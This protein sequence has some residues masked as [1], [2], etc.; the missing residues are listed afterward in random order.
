[1]P[2][3]V[4]RKTLLRLEWPQVLE[5]L[6]RHARTARGR[7]RLGQAPEAPFAADPAAA[8]LQLA[9][10]SEARGILDAGELPP[11]EANE[12]VDALLARLQR[13]GVLSGPE[14]LGLAASARVCDETRRV[15]VRRAEAAP[16]LAEL[17]GNLGDLGE[18]TRHVEG[19]L[20]ADGSVR[21]SASPA[22]AAARR[23]ARELAA[24]VHERISRFLQDRELR[25]VLQD[26]YVTLRSDRFVLPVRAD[27]RSRMPG[28]VH[29]ASAS[30]T[31]LFIEPQAVVEL[32]NALKQ[33]GLRVARETQ[34]VLNTLSELAGRRAEDLDASLER[35]AEID[36]A[37]ARGHLSREM[38]AVEPLLDEDGCFQLC[39]M[40]HP[41]L[42]STEVVPND[43]ALGEHFHV[44]VISG[45]NA[46]GKTVAMKALALMALFVRAG[47][48]VPAAPGARVALMERVLADIGDDQD[49]RESL[50]TFSA[51]MANLAAI[52]RAADPGSLVVLDEVGAGTD[53]GEGAALAQ[54][55]LETLADAGAR[56]VITTHFNLLKEM[57]DVDERFA[58]AS[59]AFD[60]ATLAPTYQLRFGTAG[61]SSATAV[62][63]RMG[64]P[65]RVVERASA[66]LAREDRR[67]DRMLQELS[68]S[69]A[70]LERERHE[71]LL[72]RAESESARDAYR[73]RLERL[74]T[75]RDQLFESMRAELERAFRDAH[76][77]VAGVIRTLQRAGTAQQAARARERLLALEEQAK[78]AEVRQRER[79]SAAAGV[80]PRAQPFG[81]LRPRMDWGR[82]RPGDA[83]CLAGGSAGTLLQLP[84]RHG[85]VLI[86]A[87]S[88]RMRVAADEIQPAP[89]PRRERTPAP[90]GLPTGSGGSSRLDLR[91]ERV[92]AALAL[93]DHALD[94]A[95][96]HGSTVL[97]IVHGVGSGALQ[98]AVRRH[99]A[100]VAWLERVEPGEPMHRGVTRAW[101][102]V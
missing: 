18:L 62:A 19:A 13:G 22:L 37:F 31:T 77:E 3:H 14:L 70:S 20:E 12:Q 73:A 27:A 65:I 21:D 10:T 81:R 66:L 97:E 1:V 91:G 43:L 87:G 82:A 95:A 94:D 92:E 29:D 57:A 40:R 72:L 83:V 45:P 42:P 59:V 23:E 41:L 4:S 75:R 58:N 50:S 56:V 16:G 28:I 80:R 63:A 33:A 96:R 9:L 17:A 2:F 89:A 79:S 76:G 47:L 35:L 48:H 52:V 46:G 60:A 36:L 53:P 101:L 26:T 34:Q 67:L 30:G 90:G 61:S 54:S 32:N 84:D 69:R 71:A 24:S 25:D 99:L 78:S 93:L 49:L 98:S 100:D 55:V 7:A 51:H 15:L 68:A 5:R 44:L 8:R 102:P 39:Q 6:T 64:M 74:Q 11:L 85:Q 88:A 86:Q 38:Q